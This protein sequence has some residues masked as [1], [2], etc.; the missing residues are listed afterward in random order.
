MVV[1]VRAH[2]STANSYC[3][4]HLLCVVQCI[5]TWS[6]TMNK[7]RAWL[8]LGASSQRALTS[9]LWETIRQHYF[10]SS[11]TMYVCYVFETLM[12]EMP[13]PKKLWALMYKKVMAS[14]TRYQAL[15][16]ELTPVYRQSACRWLYII[17]LAV[18]CRYFPP[19]LRLPSQ[20]HSVTAPW[21]APSYT[22]WWQRH[23]CVNNLP[24][25]V[26]QLCP[27]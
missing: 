20:P 24:K 21:P 8:T 15:G 17:H 14:N 26:M 5:L 27:E 16:P 13:L 18:G 7:R 1:V 11:R 22:A 6:P 4:P 25:V 12:C 19:G 9:S 23:I 3:R 2:T 10:C